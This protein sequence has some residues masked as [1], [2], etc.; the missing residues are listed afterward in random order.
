MVKN[1]NNSYNLK[2]DEKEYNE[3]KE[4]LTSFFLDNNYVPMTF[5]QIAGILNVNKEKQDL[6][7]YIIN[8]LL[9]ECFIIEDD[10]KRYVL[11][12]K[13]K[14][15]KCKYE[16]K[17]EKFGFGITGS[18][19]DIFI[20]A[21]DSMGAYTGDEILVKVTNNN[22][23]ARRSKEGVVVKVLKTNDIWYGITYKE[24]VEYV[25]KSFIELYKNGVY[26]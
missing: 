23:G 26:K 3:K 25:K 2:V 7:K 19:D 24:D 6:L 4:S 1:I 17:G 15:I 11:Y 16:S 13:S 21:V 8:E 14:L 12:T 9:D 20:L 5:K 22:T 10:S 18:G